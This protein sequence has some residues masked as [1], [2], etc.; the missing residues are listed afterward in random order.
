MINQ[1]VLKEKQIT[2]RNIL[3]QSSHENNQAKPLK[4]ER[5]NK[6]HF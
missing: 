1:I 4:K 2:N 6:V 5:K 3:V